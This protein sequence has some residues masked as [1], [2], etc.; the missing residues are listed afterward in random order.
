MTV[1]TNSGLNEMGRRRLRAGE[2]NKVGL[3]IL[4]GAVGAALVAGAIYATS[5]LG[6]QTA[7]IT[8]TETTGSAPT[9][10][11]LPRPRPANL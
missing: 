10:V 7:L 2:A 8:P 5:Y 6:T 3:W 1:Q 9:T 4:L 11:P